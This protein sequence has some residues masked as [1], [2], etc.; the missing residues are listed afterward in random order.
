MFTISGKISISSYTQQA[1][2]IRS[3]QVAGCSMIVY[4]SG[5]LFSR[6]A[7]IIEANKFNGSG[8]GG[9]FIISG[10]V[11]INFKIAGNKEKEARCEK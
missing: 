2:K 4:A 1:F 10:R 9:S 8:T 3:P 5:R 6:M 11:L 7:H